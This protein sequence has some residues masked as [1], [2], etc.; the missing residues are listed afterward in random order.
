[1][2]VTKDLTWVG[3]N[4]RHISMFENLYPIP[5][6]MAYNSY[7]LEDEKT[8]LFDTVDN[9]VHKQF[10]E[11]LFYVLGNRKLDYLV[12]HHMEPD[13]AAGI[14]DVLTH[15]PDVQVVC[16][17]RTQL[18]FEQFFG[19]NKDINYHIVMEN[20][21]L[22]TGRH[23][24]QFIMA[25]MVHWPEVMVTYDTTDKILFSAD[26]FGSFGT[27]DGALFA[28]EINYEKEYLDEMR[29][30]YANIVGKYGLQTQSLLKKAAS[31]D[32]EIIC[33]LH[34]FVWRSKIEEI[35]SKYNL[36][37]SYVSEELGV[38]I[39]YGSI[40]G[41]TETA[42]EILASKLHEREIQTTLFDASNTHVSQLVSATFQWSH[43]VLAS[44]TY[45]G[46]LFPPI[47]TLIDQLTTRNFQ[48]R[49]IGVIENG[50]WAITSGNLI[51]NKL[52]KSKNI[53]ML[54]SSVSIESSLKEKNLLQI[55][56][57]ADEI[58]KSMISL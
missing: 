6:G 10:M 15:Y 48:N 18:F 27:L 40:Y 44:V 11:N 24:F 56:D 29:R 2:K 8:V 23:T 32:I 53:N 41:N 51:R 14:M 45:N 34:G 25:P 7:L 3:G 46:G 36:W 21:T 22:T 17:E 54:S 31:L 13:H 52:E 38:V 5:K 43:L 39:V 47:G 37:S 19:P 28:D 50:T 49:T 35:I 1:M 16:T 55:E 26:A 58:A 30:Y 4:D 33:P 9:A 12:V 20:D 42:A 57:M